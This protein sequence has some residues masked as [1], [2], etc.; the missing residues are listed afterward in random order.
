MNNGHIAGFRAVPRNGAN[1]PQPV[2]GLV[3]SGY[4]GAINGGTSIDI[5]AGDPVRR[6]STGYFEIADGSEGAGGGETIWGVCIGFE[7]F[8]DSALG[9]M[10]LGD[11]LPGGAVYGTNF[12][13][14]SK[15]LVQRVT[16]CDWEIDCDDA[17]T[18]TTEALYLALIGE[19]CDHIFLTG[20]EP[21]SNCMLDI[22]GHATTAAQWQILGISPSLANQDFSGLYVKLLVTI[23]EGQIAPFSTTGV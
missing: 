9:N 21:K 17:T 15:I 14:Q 8:Y 20:S 22:S 19:N 12:T 1:L 2:R 4:Q 18:A 3:A 10:R 11:K 6:L 23:N 13:R 7:P 16:D 5:N